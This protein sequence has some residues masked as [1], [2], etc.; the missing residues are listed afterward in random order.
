M[1]DVRVP[2]TSSN[3]MDYLDHLR[4]FLTALVVCHH[5]SIAFGAPGGWYYK[6]A[7]PTDIPSLVVM[8]MF[9]AVNQA[10]F[11]SLF[12]FVSAY[13]TRMSLLKKGAPLFVRDRLIRLAI[14]L[15]VYFFV[16]NPSVGYLVRRFTGRTDAGYFGFMLHNAPQCFG[17]G[18]MWFVLSLILFTAAYLA[19]RGMRQICGAARPMPLPGNLAVF[20]FILFIGTATFL[21]RLAYPVGREFIGLQLGYFPMYICMFAFGILAHRSSWPDQLERRQVNVWFGLAM[22]AILLL[23]VIVLLGGAFSGNADK[24]PG[25]LSWQAY[26]YSAWE[27]FLCIG[28]SLKLLLLFRGRL[29]RANTLSARLSKS[30]YTVY[31]LHPFFVVVAT[32]LAKD[33]PLPPLVIVL[34]ICPLVLAVNFA[35]ANLI[36]QAPFLNK[37]L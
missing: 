1:Q 14:P 20:L 36:R 12:F 27:P 30:S 22:A 29:N 6:V 19:V 21:V 4:V 16:L 10:F 33:L 5:Q 13:F 9:V 3:R 28:I 2:E 18:P 37:V 8:T 25:G 31:I 7:A 35:C 23:P 17:W 26:V 15:M 24:F 34:L 32:W 11:M